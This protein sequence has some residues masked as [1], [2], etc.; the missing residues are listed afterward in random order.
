MQ[1]LKCTAIRTHAGDLAYKDN[2]LDT[3]DALFTGCLHTYLSGNSMFCTS[4]FVG[5]VMQIP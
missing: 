3:D 4:M 2:A 5:S 1:V